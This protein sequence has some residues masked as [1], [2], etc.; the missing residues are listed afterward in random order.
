MVSAD[1]FMPAE[2]FKPSSLDLV[3]VKNLIQ[4][5]IESVS[6]RTSPSKVRQYKAQRLQCSLRQK[7]F[8]LR[9]LFILIISRHNH[10]IYNFSL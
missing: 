9:F 3:T 8:D 7:C 10:G 2:S 5:D 6:K 1:T 4:N